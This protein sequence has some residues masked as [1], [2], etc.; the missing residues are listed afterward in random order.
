[1]KRCN[2]TIASF[3]SEYIY[4]FFFK[5]VLCVPYKFQLSWIIEHN[6]FSVNT[7]IESMDG[8][9]F[10][11]FYYFLESQKLFICLGLMEGSVIFKLH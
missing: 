1:M 10:Y 5:A 8:Y 2:D 7:I 11:Q 9:Q 6:H 3:A 4:Q